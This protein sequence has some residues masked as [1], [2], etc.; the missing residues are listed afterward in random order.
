[1]SSSGSSNSS[2]DFDTPGRLGVRS[3]EAH[4]SGESGGVGRVASEANGGCGPGEGGGFYRERTISDSSSG[5]SSSGSV[6]RISR[7]LSAHSS[8]DSLILECIER[9]IREGNGAVMSMFP[10]SSDASVM[11]ARGV[12]AGASAV[13]TVA[14]R[15]FDG[16]KNP[17]QAGAVAMASAA[18]KNR[19]P[20]GGPGHDHDEPGCYPV[21]A[22]VFPETP[23]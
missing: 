17:D 4:T 10:S 1:M 19:P 7:R 14:E 23:T 11:E 16:V 5:S 15:S 3:P 21:R 18:A 13:L 12:A 6:F 8:L 22:L 9:R 2:G 20:S